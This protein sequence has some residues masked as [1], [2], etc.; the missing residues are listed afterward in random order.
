M[1]FKI[2]L[3]KTNKR[4]TNISIFG[5]SRSQSYNLKWKVLNNTKKFFIYIAMLGLYTQVQDYLLFLYEIIQ[6]LLSV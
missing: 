1:N 4:R 5:L 3:P 6:L 2:E